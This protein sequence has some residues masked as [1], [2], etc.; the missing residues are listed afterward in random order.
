MQPE[1][2]LYYLRAF[3]LLIMISWVVIVLYPSIRDAI[4]TFKDQHHS[5][6]R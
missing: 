5:V 3:G 4:R 6:T 2:N 1:L